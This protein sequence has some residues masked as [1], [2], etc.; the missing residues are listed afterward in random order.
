[1][2]KQFN[3]QIASGMVTQVIGKE[4]D[5]TQFVRIFNQVHIFVTATI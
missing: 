2:T 3:R 1:M 5:L 4:L